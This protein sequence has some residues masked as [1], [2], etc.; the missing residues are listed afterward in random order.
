MWE[1]MSFGERPYWDM[2]NQDVSIS[3]S[4]Q[5]ALKCLVSWA[6]GRRGGRGCLLRELITV[7]SLRWG[8]CHGEEVICVSSL[9]TAH[10]VTDGGRDGGQA[11]EMSGS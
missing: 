7:G 4:H 10:L 9:I 1:V 2:S 5:P 3:W 11:W 6:V 8:E